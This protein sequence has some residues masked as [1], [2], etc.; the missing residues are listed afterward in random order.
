MC[1][2]CGERI[3]NAWS[4]T[5]TGRWLT[6]ENTPRPK[7]TKAVIG[8]AL[9]T[10]VFERDEY[11]CRHCDTHLDL[12]ADHVIPESAGGPTTLANLRTLCRSCNSKKGTRD[13]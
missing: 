8:Q 6:R 10:Q 3:A 4:Y 2:P 11:R 12:T 1:D 7:P 9:R 5:H 13:A